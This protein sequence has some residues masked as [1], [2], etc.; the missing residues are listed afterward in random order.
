MNIEITKLF[1]SPFQM[2]LD[3][4]W[5]DPGLHTPRPDQRTVLLMLRAGC[6]SVLPTSFPLPLIGPLKSSSRHLCSFYLKFSH[7]VLWV[8]LCS[9]Y[10]CQHSYREFKPGC[11]TEITSLGDAFL[12]S[13]ATSGPQ[14]TCHF[15][16]HFFSS[17][18]PVP[19]VSREIPT[20]YSDIEGHSL[21]SLLPLSFSFKMVVC[22]HVCCVHM[23]VHLCALTCVFACACSCACMRVVHVLWNNGLAPRKDLSLVL[24]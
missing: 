23:C 24:I 16:P 21:S 13:P 8:F 19:S 14:S 18:T 3:R 7:A 2:S 15:L 10:Q 20:S 11:P 17:W 6:I 5:P 12:Q 9:L 22:V 4:G 1:H